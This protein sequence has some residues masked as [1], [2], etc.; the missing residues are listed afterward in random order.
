M[1]GEELELDLLSVRSPDK[2]VSKHSK[3]VFRAELNQDLE[4]LMGRLAGSV[5]EACNS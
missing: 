4:T 1:R 3:V 2:D 5:L